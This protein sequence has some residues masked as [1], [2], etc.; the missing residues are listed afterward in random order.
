MQVLFVW[1]VKQGC[2]VYL[3]VNC[4]LCISY[5]KVE[6][7]L[8][9][10]VVYFDLVIIVV[11]IVEKNINVYLFD[12]FKLLLVVIVKGDFGSMVDLV[13]KIQMVNFLINLDIMGGN[14]GLLVFNVW[15]ELIGLNFD[16]NWELVSVS[17]W[18]DLCYKCV[19]Y[20]DMCYLCWLLVKVYLVFELLKEMDVLVE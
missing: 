3:D 9:C 13:L 1:C 2:V 20:V 19:V 18:F 5:G 12:V 11:G 8:L 10:D 14:L 4:I 6:V 17:W 16:S 7:L 15:G